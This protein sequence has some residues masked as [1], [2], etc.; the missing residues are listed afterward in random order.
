MLSAKYVARLIKVLNVSKKHQADSSLS[1]FAAVKPIIHEYKSQG[2]DIASLLNIIDISEEQQVADLLNEFKKFKPKIQTCRL[3]EIRRRREYAPEWNV[4]KV[5]GVES[6]EAEFHTPF[7]FGLL[8]P[9]GVHGQGRL[10]LD[11]F[12]GRI[13]EKMPE[14]PKDIISDPNWYVEREVEHVALRI[15]NN[16]LKKGIYIEN[17]VYTETRRGQLS[18]YVKLWQRQYENSD[19]DG[20]IFYLTVRGDE[21]PDAAFDDAGQFTRQE[22]EREFGEIRLLSYKRDIR[23]WLDGMV[24]S[25]KPPK[26]RQSINQYI[27]VI[28][29][30]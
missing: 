27:E 4:F 15:C 13:G 1:G 19:R 11:S 22:I 2:I 3:E 7:L 9:D 5:L 14:F 6:K 16:R 18:K 26:L 25:V 8:N 23:N 28:N 12:L 20:G 24:D 10:F 21:P 17:K 29:N 30:L